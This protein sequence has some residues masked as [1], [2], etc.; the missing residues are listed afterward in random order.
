[1]GLA[2]VF[3][4]QGYKYT[5]LTNAVLLYNMCPVYVMI[6]SKFFLKEKITFIK[7]VSILGCFLGL[8]LLIQQ[9]L[10]LKGLLNQGLLWALSSGILCAII[11]KLNKKANQKNNNIDTI[12]ITFIQL[13]DASLAL[14]TYQIKNDSF[15]KVLNLDLSNIILLLILAIIHTAIA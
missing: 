3:L 14:L 1:M 10:N 7:F 12:S 2:W 4:F 8:Y 5:T 6:F 13:L 15:I 11:V 9:D